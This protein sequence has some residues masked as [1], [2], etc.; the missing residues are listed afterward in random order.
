MSHIYFQ[1]LI[2]EKILTDDVIE[3]AIDSF[4]QL[5]DST[6]NEESKWIKNNILPQIVERKMING[7]Q[8]F[9]DYIWGHCFPGN[10][11]GLIEVYSLPKSFLDAV[12]KR[13][14]ARMMLSSE[15][16]GGNVDISTFTYEF[17]ETKYL[18]FENIIHGNEEEQIPFYTTRNDG[19]YVIESMAELGFYLNYC[20]KLD[21]VEIAGKEYAIDVFKKL[22]NKTLSAIDLDYNKSWI[23][24]MLTTTF[25]ETKS[26]ITIEVENH[27]DLTTEKI[28]EKVLQRLE[29]EL[30]LFTFGSMTDEKIEKFKEIYRKDDFIVEIA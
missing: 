6:N 19:G 28:Q 1:R 12:N 5:L 3:N 7:E 25:N 8:S 26:K 4:L 27:P 15:N 29:N 24:R 17:N 10:N 21:E 30:V 20:K 11:Y 2:K 23:S 9:I 16:I 14:A 13:M 22:I 18:I